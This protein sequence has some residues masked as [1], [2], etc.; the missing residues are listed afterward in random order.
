M[1]PIP[2]VSDWSQIVHVIRELMEQSPGMG[3]IV[4]VIS[5]LVISTLIVITTWS[6]IRIIRARKTPQLKSILSLVRVITEMMSER[7]RLSRR[8]EHI[9]ENSLIRDQMAIVEGTL[10]DIQK[11]LLIELS[12]T[13]TDNEP[14][15]SNINITNSSSY[16]EA[17]DTLTLVFSDVHV[18]LRRAI[19]ENHIDDKTEAE[20]FDYVNEKVSRMKTL[21]LQ[22][23]NVRSTKI[24]VDK[25]L[26]ELFDIHWSTLEPMARKMFQN[27]RYIKLKYKALIDEEEAL[28]DKQWTE[29]MNKVPEILTKGQAEPELEVLDAVSD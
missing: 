8:H 26:S 21:I 5:L 15:D 22:N 25:R 2:N 14:D 11:H 12:R 7:D 29:F 23:I 1:D 27:L 3:I 17:K 4:I 24:S 16:L 18:A 10:D 13:L 20:F 6:V 9:K 28:F 19:K